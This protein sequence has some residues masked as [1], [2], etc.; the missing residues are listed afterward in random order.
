MPQARDGAVAERLWDIS[1]AP[2][3]VAFA[4]VATAA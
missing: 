4:Q 2:T 3:G 1:A